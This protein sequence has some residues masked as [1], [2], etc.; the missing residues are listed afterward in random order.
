[1]S[2]VL[3]IFGLNDRTF[4]DNDMRK[5]FLIFVIVFTTTNICIA[6]DYY[7]MIQK[8][9]ETATKEHETAMSNVQ[10][11][12]VI[13]N[14]KNCYLSVVDK[15]IDKEYTQNK[16]QMKSEFDGFAK[17]SYDLAYSM[18]YAD[19][20]AP[21]CGTNIGI[22]AANTNLEIIK[23]YVRQLLSVLSSK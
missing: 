18:Q 3:L 19:T 17:N 9:D 15:I 13:D 1:M 16:Q 4:Y 6:D 2:I 23:N 10:I 11:T 5:N 12:R 8:C 21:Y 7:A 22:N 20:C 14:Q